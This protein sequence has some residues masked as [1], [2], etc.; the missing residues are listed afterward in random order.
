MSVYERFVTGQRGRSQMRSATKTTVKE[1]SVTQT[2]RYTGRIM[3]AIQKMANTISSQSGIV[4]AG[5]LL[6]DL[7]RRRARTSV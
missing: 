1:P 5:D 7:L 6:A 4:H 2:M 3:Q